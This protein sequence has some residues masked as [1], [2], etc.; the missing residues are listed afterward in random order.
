MCEA[1]LLVNVEWLGMT[2]NDFAWFRVMGAWVRSTQSCSATSHALM[3]SIMASTVL[4]SVGGVF[5][6]RRFIRTQPKGV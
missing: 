2:L 5:V 1:D 3:Y 6:W 4:I